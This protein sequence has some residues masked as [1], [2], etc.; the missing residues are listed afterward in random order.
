MKASEF[1]DKVW[2]I[3]GVRIILRTDPDTK[4]PDYPYK[5]AADE[6]WRVTELID[7]RVAKLINDIPHVVLQGDGEEPHGKVILRTIRKGYTA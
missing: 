1:E 7:K 3:E 4:V 5:K 2:A 6:S